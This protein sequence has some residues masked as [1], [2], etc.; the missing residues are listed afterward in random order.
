MHTWYQSNLT[1]LIFS[2]QQVHS[3]LSSLIYLD[4]LEYQMISFNPSMSVCLIVVIFIYSLIHDL[5]SPSMLKYFYTQRLFDSNLLFF[6]FSLILWDNLY[7]T[8]LYMKVTIYCP[9][10]YHIY[11]LLDMFIRKLYLTVIIIFHS[12][13]ILCNPSYTMLKEVHF[14]S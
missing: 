13:S 6:C 1:Q 7:Q 8:I 9:N 14:S 5:C 11:S 3:H 10:I 4:F 12:M 2:H